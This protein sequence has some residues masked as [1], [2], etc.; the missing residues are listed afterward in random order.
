MIIERSAFLGETRYN[1]IAAKVA[2][3]VELNYPFGGG[4]GGGGGW[5]GIIYKS[6]ERNM[7]TTDLKN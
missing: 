2:Y 4:G 6:L 7:K 1:L 3:A 5:R